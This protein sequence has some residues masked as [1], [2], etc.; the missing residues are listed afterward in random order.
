MTGRFAIIT[1][2]WMIRGWDEIPYAIVNSVSGHCIPISKKGMYIANSCDGRTD[3]DSL[4][5]LPE[6]KDILQQLVDD[7]IVEYCTFGKLISDYQKYGKASNPFIKGIHWAITSLCNLHC[8]HCYMEAPSGRYKDLSTKAILDIIEQLSNAGVLQVQITGGEPF[9]RKDL[10]VILKE[11]SEKRISVTQFYSNGLLIND[12]ILNEIKS[13]GY[14]PVFLISFDGHGFH[15]SMRGKSNIETEVWG[16][17]CRIVEDGFTVS[18]ASSIDKKNVKA[19]PDT[20]NL[21]K[22]MGIKSWGIAAPT[23]AGFWKHS[24]TDLSL[25]DQELAY[26]SIL[27]KWQDD[28]MPFHLKLGLFFDSDFDV[29]ENGAPRFTLRYK[30]EDFDCGACRQYP[31]LMSDGTLLP[32]SLYTGTELMA[33]MPNLTQSKL[34]CALKMPSFTSIV[35][36][37]KETLLRDNNEC[38]ACHLFDRCGIGCRA[39][40]TLESGDL[41]TKDKLACMFWKG[42][43]KERLLK[44]GF[45]AKWNV[46]SITY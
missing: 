41:N 18:I 10:S 11:L 14:N 31:H 3:F 22:N 1:E 42:G 15:D 43:Y 30:K 20:Y 23:K 7:G 29:F 32:C 2:P 37:K 13:L 38:A 28:G 34:S 5:F 17:I 16:K 19:L 27:R 4:L 40:A 46:H 25:K 33:T 8:R 36:R 24:K 45:N 6:H 44:N 35:E 39:R 9:I 12:H 26:I 21:L